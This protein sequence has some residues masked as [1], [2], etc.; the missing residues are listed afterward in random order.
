VANLII[1]ILKDGEKKPK[2]HN[3]LWIF[4]LFENKIKSPSCK[5]SPQKEKTWMKNMMMMM[6][7]VS[8]HHIDWRG[9]RNFWKC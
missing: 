4:S 5:N 1:F 7:K 2:N 8:I 3:F 6:I 9:R